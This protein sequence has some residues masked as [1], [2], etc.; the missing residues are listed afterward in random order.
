LSVG[1]NA[2]DSGYQWSIV[3]KVVGPNLK[4]FVI[5]GNAGIGGGMGA[6]PGLQPGIG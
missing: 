3:Q 2:S 6:K 5:H 1:A 4:E